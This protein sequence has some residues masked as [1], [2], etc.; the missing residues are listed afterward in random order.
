[1]CGLYEVLSCNG[2]LPSIP[3]CKNHIQNVVEQANCR[4]TNIL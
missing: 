4:E 3:I 2:I 1:M